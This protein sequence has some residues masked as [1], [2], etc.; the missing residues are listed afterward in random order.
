[1]LKISK[2]SGMLLRSHMLRKYGKAETSI[3]VW[4]FSKCRLLMAVTEEWQPVRS[5]GL[6][7]FAI[8]TTPSC[9]IRV[10][11]TLS[12]VASAVAS[13]GRSPTQR[14]CHTQSGLHTKLTIADSQLSHLISL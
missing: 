8:Y 5:E 9:S 12:A 6:G 7:V 3:A 4:P 1:L 11:C 14:P 13:K 2:T 10:S